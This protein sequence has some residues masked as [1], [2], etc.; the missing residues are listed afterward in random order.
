MNRRVYESFQIR[1]LSRYMPESWIAGLYDNS[2]LS[3]LKNLQ[4]VPIVVQGLMDLT[5]NDEVVGFIPGLAQWVKD[6][7]LL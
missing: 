6:P 3:F 1:V 4:G 5:R 7:A 2:T